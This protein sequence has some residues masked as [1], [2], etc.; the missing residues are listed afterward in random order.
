MFLQRSISACAIQGVTIVALFVSPIMAS[1]QSVG[2]TDKDGDPRTASKIAIFGVS[3]LPDSQR[4]V[5]YLRTRQHP[6]IVVVTRVQGGNASDL[7]AGYEAALKL[8]RSPGLNAAL[9]RPDPTQMRVIV[10][11]S[12][13]ARISATQKTAF[14]AYYGYLV[15]APQHRSLPGIGEGQLIYIDKRR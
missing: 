8:V 13:V 5:V 2:A 6:S 4:A 12:D 11:Q 9:S 3:A 15:K 10:K 7:A 1:G 14:A